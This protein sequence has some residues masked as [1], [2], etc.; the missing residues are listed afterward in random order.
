MGGADEYLLSS[1]SRSPVRCR[2]VAIVEIRQRQFD[3]DVADWS[4]T[5]PIQLTL[6]QTRTTRTQTQTTLVL[7]R[8]LGGSQ[9]IGRSGQDV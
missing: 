7:S 1:A 8:V 4:P 9:R 5:R 3:Q 6:H 2:N